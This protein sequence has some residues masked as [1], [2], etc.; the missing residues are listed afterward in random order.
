MNRGNRADEF[1]DNDGL[2]NTRSAK[3][4]SLATF[5]EGR[6]QVNHLD[7]SFK[8]L[9]A[10]GLLGKKRGGSM[11]GVV[12]ICRNLT[13]IVHRATQNVE[14]AAQGGSPYRDQDGCTGSFGRETALQAI[15]G[16]HRNTAH[17]VITQVLLHFQHQ[18]STVFAGDLKGFKNV[19][20][21]ACRKLNIDNT[22]LNLND[23]ACCIHHLFHPVKILSVLIISGVYNN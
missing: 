12:L 20:E 19:G 16:I 7:T 6:D 11:N 18:F 5:G 22:S 3:D 9:G 21:F 17:P 1:L 2:A 15:G 8:N 14:N 13:F 10:G 23:T 4:A